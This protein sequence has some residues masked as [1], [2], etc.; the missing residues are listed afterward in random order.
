MNACHITLSYKTDHHGLWVSSTGIFCLLRCVF[1]F[2]TSRLSPLSSPVFKADTLIIN[3]ISV[4]LAV[5]V[6]P[7]GER[8]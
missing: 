7:P 6:G 5:W 4:W 1:V 2:L 3:V 8:R